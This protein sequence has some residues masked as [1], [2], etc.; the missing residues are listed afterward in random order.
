MRKGPE[1]CGRGLSELPSWGATPPSLLRFCERPVDQLL[2]LRKRL[3]AAD[4][5]A[6]DDERGR[7]GDSGVVPDL[8]VS[9]DLRLVGV[10]VERCLELVHVEA[11]LLGV[12]L[13]SGALD[14]VGRA[15][16]L[17]KQ[18]VHLPETVGALLLERLGGS[19]GSEGRV[20]VHGEG[21]VTPDELHLVAVRIGDL[22]HRRLYASAERAL[23]VA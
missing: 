22:L 20:G 21:L 19:L 10:C 13:E 2:E 15:L 18:V 5:V 4:E 8:R 17:E 6:V 11:E 9:V 1:P 7:A 16:V 23:K 14:A 3:G 12:L